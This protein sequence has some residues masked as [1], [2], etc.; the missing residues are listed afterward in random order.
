M[1]AREFKAFFAAD[2][3]AGH[4]D[5]VADDHFDGACPRAVQLK[6]FEPDLLQTLERLPVRYVVD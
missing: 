1:L 3:T 5:L 4:I 2:L 6:L